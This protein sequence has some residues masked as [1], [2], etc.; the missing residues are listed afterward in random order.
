M[1]QMSYRTFCKLDNVTTSSCCVCV[2]VCLH[3]CTLIFQAIEFLPVKCFSVGVC[4][5]AESSCKRLPSLYL[6]SH[7]LCHCFTQRSCNCRLLLA[8]CIFNFVHNCIY[9]SVFIAEAWSEYI[10]IFPNTK[11]CMFAYTAVTYS[12]MEVYDDIWTHGR[13]GHLLCCLYFRLVTMATF[14]LRA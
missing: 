14:A 13:T 2:C 3:I 6:L 5:F 11:T 9:L 12:Q 7:L 1:I 4:W 10:Q 8:R